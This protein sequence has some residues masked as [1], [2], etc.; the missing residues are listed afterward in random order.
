[1]IN[2]PKIFH[3]EDDKIKE[4]I[5]ARNNLENYYYSVMKILNENNKNI[6]EFDLTLIS[7][8]CNETINW[9]DF[10]KMVD[11]EECIKYMIQHPKNIKNN[12]EYFNNIN[13]K[14][15]ISLIKNGNSL[16]LLSIYY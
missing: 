15:T 6:S 8:K 12:V 4:M 2:E 1:M 7:N 10:N 3:S 16:L 13:F 5:A 11:K 9:L 14:I